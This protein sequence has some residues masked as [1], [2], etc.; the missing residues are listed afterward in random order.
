M[1]LDWMLDKVKAR[2]GSENRFAEISSMMSRMREE[3]VEPGPDISREFDEVS[4]SCFE[5][6][7]APRV[8]YDEAATEFFREKVYEPAR[9]DALEGVGNPEFQAFWRRSFEECLEDHRGRYVVELARE[10]GGEATVT[11][12][13]A[14]SLDFRGKVV[15]W[16]EEVVGAALAEE[17]YEDHTAEECLSYAKRLEEALGDRQG[18]EV[19]YLRDAVAWLRF[20]GERGFGYHA[21]S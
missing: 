9:A 10:R 17:A 2:P 15:G 6:I 13:L 11:G 21:W 5:A 4:V 12:V 18:D 1:G 16:S 19:K 7:G 14:G 20:W 3:G 8:G